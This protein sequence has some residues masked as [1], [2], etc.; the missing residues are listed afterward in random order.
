MCPVNSTQSQITTS[1]S[2]KSR[3]IW[4]WNIPLLIIIII[5][6]SSNFSLLSATKKEKLKTG[7]RNWFPHF[8]FIF[9]RTSKA[10]YVDQT[11]IPIIEY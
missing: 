4:N 8:K 3:R 5:S 11:A 10:S 2:H 7:K 1:L 6:S 9:F